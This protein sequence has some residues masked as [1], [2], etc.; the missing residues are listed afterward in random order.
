M[1]KKTVKSLNLA[2]RSISHFAVSFEIQGGNNDSG[3]CTLLQCPV[4][5]LKGVCILT[6]TGCATDHTR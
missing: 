1:R 3:Q 4:S 5:I 2:K 6:N